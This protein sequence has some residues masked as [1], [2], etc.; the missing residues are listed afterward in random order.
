MRGKTLP[1]KVYEEV[2]TWYFRCADWV[3][4]P[5]AAWFFAFDGNSGSQFLVLSK[6]FAHQHQR[7]SRFQVFYWTFSPPKQYYG[8]LS[9]RHEPFAKRESFWK[10]SW[11]QCNAAWILVIWSLTLKHCQ[12]HNG[13]EGWV[14]ITSSYT[15]LNQV[16]ISES[17]LLALTSKSQPNISMLKHK[18]L[19]KASSK[20]PT[21]LQLWNLA[22]TSTSKSWPN[23]VLKI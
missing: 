3:A 19:T 13:P 11:L 21:K 23:L 10:F 14:H 4:C 17:W 5:D 22:W 18:I 7:E 20:K 9:P 6:S 1:V 2:A 8:L 16:S 12:R 15:N